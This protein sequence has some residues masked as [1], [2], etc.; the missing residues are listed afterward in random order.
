MRLL[1]TLAKFILFI[2]VI[3]C[4]AGASLFWLPTG[5]Q[6]IQ[7]LTKWAV[8][9][10]FPPLKLNADIT[11]SIHDGYQIKNLKIIS[12]DTELLKLDNFRVSPD[13]DLVL[14]G[15]DGLPFIKSLEIDGV[16]SDLDKINALVNFFVPESS[17]TSPKNEDDEENSE[18]FNLKLNP[19]NL[20]ASNIYFGTPQIDLDLQKFLIS[21][22][23]NIILK[24]NLISRDNILP[25]NA[26][27]LLN[28]DTLEIPSS[29]LKIGRGSGIL[30]AKIFPLDSM[31]VKLFLTALQLDDFMKF[32]PQQIDATGRVDA[33]LFYDTEGASGV[34]SM[35]RAK[36]MNV[37]LKFRLPFNWDGANKFSLSNV[38]LK[39]GVA[40]INLDSTADLSNMKITANGNAENISLREIGNIFA[41][42]VK[43]EGERGFLKFNLDMIASGDILNNINCDLSAGLPFLNAMGMKI[44]NDFK[45][46]A[47][48]KPGNTPKISLDGKIFNGKLF[49]RGEAKT[50]ANGEFKPQAVISVVNLDLATLVNAIP[51][52]KKSVNKPSGKITA[53]AVIAENLDINAEI[54]SDRLSVNDIAITNTTADISYSVQKNNAAI[55]NFTTTLGKT[56]A[57]K[58]TGYANLNTGDFKFF[59]NVRNL[60]PNEILK[61][62]KDLTGIFNADAQASGNFNNV[63]TINAAV[64]LVANNM[65]YSGMNFGNLDVPATYSDNRIAIPAARVQTPGGNILFRGNFDVA[66]PA[67]PNIN[68]ALTSSGIDL[69]KIFKAFKLENNSFPVNGNVRG[70]VNVVGKLNTAKVF[71]DITA[72]NIRAGDLVNMPTAN[73]NAEGDMREIKLKKLNAK[74]N[75]ADLNADGNL[76]LNQKNI[77]ASTFNVNATLNNFLLDPFLKRVMGSAPV[78]GML[79]A[80]A[81]ANGTFAKPELQLNVDSPITASNLKIQDIEV[82]LTSP[83]ENNFKINAGAKTGTFKINADVDLKNNNGVWAYSV[84]TKPMN[85]GDL[86][87]SFAPDAK[88]MVGGQAV[89]KVNGDTSNK[90]PIDINLTSNRV[91]ILNKIHVEKINVPV[92]FDL[93][94]NLVSMKDARAVLSEGQIR[95][96]FELDLNKSDWTSSLRVRNLNFGKLAQPF[97][98][99]GELIGS[100]DL[101]VSAKGNYGGVWPTSYANGKFRTGAGYFH[102]MAL[103]ESISPTKKIS[104]ENIKGSFFW[105]GSD[106]FFNPGTQATAAY[107]EPLYRYVSIN[108]SCGIPGKGLNLLVDGRFDLKILDQF[109][110][111]MKGIFQYMTG[112]IARNVIRDAAGRVLGLKTRDFQNVSFRLANNWNELQLLDLAI[113]KAIEDFLPVDILN[114]DSET[115]RDDKQFKL[116]IKIPTGKGD[117]SVE[118]ESTTDQFKEQLLDNLLNLGL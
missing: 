90:K 74:I 67:N 29:D 65:G 84:A 17:D 1:W 86:T 19:F 82:K 116:S 102:K 23:G 5:S 101:D 81:K 95:T 11:G 108:G 88:G 30:K 61:E 44:L 106:L 2:G 32:S 12:N 27:V 87:E 72:T 36:I 47:V 91:S 98:P 40:S 56:G 96:G 104:F 37:T 57:I 18:P 73:L 49:A 22:D 112:G 94:K 83:A 16:S 117:K 9:Y 25:L 53:R 92:K 109:L 52:L 105:N 20:S 33:K 13:W 118:E 41:P 54:K 26:N 99:E 62:L 46:H 43:L 48:L 24:S 75:M 6:I 7:P 39:T 114:R 76:K 77:M 97:L 10:F 3:L 55:E 78:T 8:E 70:V 28:F 15:L 4:A 35:P 110:G 59:A 103:I 69:A 89:L 100:A 85:L 63:K 60:K 80:R 93:N 14:N 64:R 113:T 31:D 66:Q 34:I 42:G 68:M 21:P 58:S 79:N 115:Q 111:A 45:A 51:E 50:T 71:A 107:S 38:D